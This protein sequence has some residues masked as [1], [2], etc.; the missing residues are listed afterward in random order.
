MTVEKAQDTY[1]DLAETVF[2]P[3]QG[4]YNGRLSI[5]SGQRRNFDAKI[6]EGER[7]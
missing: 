2:E 7:S 6:L 5:S 1:M 4:E 3:K